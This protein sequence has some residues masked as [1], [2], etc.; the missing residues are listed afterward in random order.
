VSQATY[1]HVGD[2]SGTPTDDLL[3]TAKS[4]GVAGNLVSV[5]ITTTTVSG[6]VGITVVGTEVSIVALRTGGDA[7]Y[8]DA[9]NLTSIAAAIN[10]N[11]AA[12]AL[13]SASVINTTPGAK[14]Y[15]TVAGPVLLSGGT[16]I[17]ADADITV[18]ITPDPAN[19]A[20]A[21]L[22][23]G[24]GGSIAPS[25]TLAVAPSIAYGP[26]ISIAPD[27]SMTA[28][29]RL[30]MQSGATITPDITMEVTAKVAKSLSALIYPSFSMT[31][32]AQVFRPGLTIC[33]VVRDILMQWGLENPCQA[34][35][36]AQLAAVNTLNQ[37]MQT[38]WNQAKDRRYWSVQTLSVTYP[39]DSAEV[40]LSNTVQN[41]VG[42]VRYSGKPLTPAS[43]RY[44]IEHYAMAFGDSGSS[45]VAYFADC[46]NQSG[47]DPAKVSIMVVPVPSTEITLSI[48]AVVEAPRYTPVSLESCPV[49]P[50]PHKYVESLLLPVARFLAMQSHLFINEENRQAIVAGYEIAQA[51]LEEANPLVESARKEKPSERP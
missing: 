37:A 38:V 41:I 30:V 9:T 50:I 12:A 46:R 32:A 2:P 35:N 5:G 19:T 36:F 15:A 13:L 29:A 40:A 42:H 24:T 3:F 7:N 45:P 21:T 47:D 49:V 51:S 48:E 43:S 18:D 28:T 22:L 14:L 11:A 31:A 6:D 33:D 44:E 27:I 17:E 25:V 34:P 10:A 26:S 16:A 1:T 23:H 4:S 20:T 39:A 8:A